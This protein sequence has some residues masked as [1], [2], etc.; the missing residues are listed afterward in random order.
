[1]TNVLCHKELAGTNRILGF[2]LAGALVTRGVRGTETFRIY[3]PSPGIVSPIAQIIAS[4]LYPF[5]FQS[6]VARL[7]HVRPRMAPAD[8]LNNITAAWIWLD[9]RKAAPYKRGLQHGSFVQLSTIGQSFQVPI[10]NLIL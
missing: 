2:L 5:L 3:K 6:S 10:Q 4:T 1:M 8:A 7:R 9:S